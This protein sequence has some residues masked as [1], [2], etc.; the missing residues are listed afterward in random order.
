MI[1]SLSKVTKKKSITESFT[2]Q[3]LSKVPGVQKVFNIHFSTYLTHI[4]LS[5]ISMSMPF[6]GTGDAPGTKHPYLRYG[7][8]ER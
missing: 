2:C 8:G 4:Y 5:M 1:S 3:T 6:L 7:L